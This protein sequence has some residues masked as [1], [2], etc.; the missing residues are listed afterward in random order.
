MRNYS[1]SRSR[2]INRIDRATQ[3][4]EAPSNDEKAKP[5]VVRQVIDAFR[6]DFIGRAV[7]A[8]IAAGV[9]AVPSYFVG[10]IRANQQ[11]IEAIEAYSSASDKILPLM[12][13]DI[14]D[15]MKSRADDS[16]VI[17][18]SA[19]IVTNRNYIRKLL[20][21][22]SGMLNSEFDHIETVLHQLQQLDLDSE[23]FKVRRD[24]L[25]NSLRE[26]IGILD[27]T[28][29]NKMVLFEGMIKELVAVKISGL[30]RFGGGNPSKAESSAP[31]SNAP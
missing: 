25:I 31:A 3:A 16:E 14:T 15:A 27:V 19:A 20:V 24:G 26:S 4:R 23:S 6:T 30:T 11:T 2:P 29:D 21:D 10:Q 9:V 5:T 13:Q 28:W 22:A 1:G 7:S 8:F 18:Y 17:R 12:T